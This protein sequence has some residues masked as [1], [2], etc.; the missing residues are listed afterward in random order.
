MGVT[1]AGVVL[2]VLA[3]CH[4]RGGRRVRR[5]MTVL[6]LD[7]ASPRPAVAL[8]SDGRL[9]EEALPGDRRASED[10]LPAVR[11]VLARAGLALR[12][13]DRVVVCA[14]PGSFTGLRVGLATAWGFGRAAG[15]PVEAVS[16]L[17]AMAEAARAPDLRSVVAALDAGRGD[18]VAERYDLSG[19]RAHSTAASTLLSADAL[20]GFAAGDAVVSLSSAGPALRRSVAA[21]LA[22]A[23]ARAPREAEGDRARRGILAIYS[24]PS[25]AEEKHGAA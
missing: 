11:T 22:E 24:R 19:P 6:A 7:T 20:G 17:E 9:F 13:C 10:L 15:I 3:Y 1:R 21:A 16:T 5:T 23:V 25:A 18:V 8:W 2:T 14:G 12:D 4:G